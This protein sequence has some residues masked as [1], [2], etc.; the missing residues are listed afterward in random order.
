MLYSPLVW[1]GFD[2][3]MPQLRLNWSLSTRSSLIHFGCIGVAPPR[4]F[5]LLAKGGVNSQGRAT[6]MQ[7]KWIKPDLYEQ[8]EQLYPS[9]FYV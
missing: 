5:T 4:L 1:R 2:K 3:I 8:Y 7:A 6:P 9:K